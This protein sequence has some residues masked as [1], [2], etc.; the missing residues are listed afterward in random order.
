MYGKGLEE[1]EAL[2]EAGEEGTLSDRFLAGRLFSGPDFLV[3]SPDLC[4]SSGA[5]SFF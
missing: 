1:C 2:G 5:L 4:V 3:C